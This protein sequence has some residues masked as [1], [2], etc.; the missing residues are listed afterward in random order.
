MD[1]KIK[2]LCSLI[3]A[4]GVIEWIY[5]LSFWWFTFLFSRTWFNGIIIL[6]SILLFVILPV[7]HISSLIWSLAIGIKYRKIFKFVGFLPLI[8]ALVIVIPIPYIGKLG[9]QLSPNNPHNFLTVNKQKE[10]SVFAEEL[11]STNLRQIRIYPDNSKSIETYD[12]NTSVTIPKLIEDKLKH[13]RF[14]VVDINSKESTVSFEY[15]RLRVWFYYIYSRNELEETFLMPTKINLEDIHDWNGIIRFAKTDNKIYFNFSSVKQLRDDFLGSTFI[16]KLKS[17]N[18][19]D[20]LT[21]NDRIFIVNALN[22]QHEVSSK[23]IEM[24]EIRLI[25]SGLDIGEASWYGQSFWVIKLGTQLLDDNI[26]KHTDKNGHMKIS[27]N[28]TEN[29]K[30]RIEWFNIGIM[31]W[32]YGDFLNKQPIIYRVKLS[33]NWYFNSW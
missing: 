7:L 27:P 12:G 14:D 19:A 15:Y 31:N 25:N 28:L 9:F 30:L 20:D 4:L 16:N 17:Y 22:K 21:A 13:Y 24:P 2:I 11:L 23:L 18:S 6:L 32:L 3:V 5:I 10:L 29:E 8:L 26:I 1:K 33:K